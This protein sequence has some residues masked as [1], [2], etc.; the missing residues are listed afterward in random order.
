M[1]EEL[2]TEQQIARLL[3][4]SRDDFDEQMAGFTG[5]VSQ[6]EAEEFRAAVQ[7]N[8]MGRVQ[9][10]MN[11]M[12]GSL[13]VADFQKMQVAVQK[14]TFVRQVVEAARA[15]NMIETKKK[16]GKA[17]QPLEEQ[18]LSQTQQLD[19]SVSYV[20]NL[21]PE[22]MR[23]GPLSQKEMENIIPFMAKERT[24]GEYKKITE[25]EAQ[26]DESAASPVDSEKIAFS[27][28]TTFNITH[29]IDHEALREGYVDSTIPDATPATDVNDINF[30]PEAKQPYR[31]GDENE[32]ATASW[33]GAP[34]IMDAN[35]TPEEADENG[36][37][38]AK[39][40]TY[41]G[42]KDPDTYDSFTGDTDFVKEGIRANN[43][44]AAARRGEAV[45]PG[46]LTDLY[47]PKGEYGFAGDWQFED[48]KKMEWLPLFE[49]TVF[50]PMKKFGNEK[51]LGDLVLDVAFTA[52]LMPVEF[53]AEALKQRRENKKESAKR[54][55]DN[56]NNAIE[57][58]LRNRGLSRNDLASRL[59]H[60][61]KNWILNDPNYAS[62]PDTGPYTKYEKAMKQKKDFAASLPRKQ[63]GDL[64]WDK[65]TKKQQKQYAEYMSSYA[66]SDKWINYT[67]EMMGVQIKKDEVI[68]QVNIAKE[69]RV[70]DPLLAKAEQSKA[71]S[72]AQ[73]AVRA[74]VS[75]EPQV[76]MSAPRR[77]SEVETPTREEV[78]RPT[79]E[80]PVGVRS[81]EEL[82]TQ[83][84][85]EELKNLEPLS[86]VKVSGTPKS[87]K[88][89]LP[90]GTVISADNKTK[91]Q[92]EEEARRVERK[93]KAL[94]E[95]AEKTNQN[96]REVSRAKAGQQQQQQQ[97]QGRTNVGMGR[98]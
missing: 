33:S 88:I 20:Y 93:A 74:P 28:K 5:K 67:R 89:T 82:K 27:G 11:N 92:L 63:N 18:F 59:A 21:Y 6:K 15:Y 94:K 40:D 36:R 68:K 45:D 77:Q 42:Y 3:K 69:M 13:D 1:A 30:S 43:D 75:Q 2:L 24:D 98:G 56:R 34:I 41:R 4:I 53:L 61:T 71:Q 23:E 65:M 17:L 86:D 72:L 95:Q 90:D 26:K 35:L 47:P 50:D 10:L 48:P 73:D 76:Q 7:S 54:L 85:L 66:M 39:P 14:N 83:K 78:Y 80:A 57:T 55:E 84:E 96:M 49:K 8:D 12:Q 44:Q 87:P 29:P 64:D 25:K 97:V 58:N 81:Q 70:D 46:K 51:E 16:E 37:L 52:A 79:L 31:F 19:Q 60:E 9:T 32:T 62:I 22:A 91:E 38:T